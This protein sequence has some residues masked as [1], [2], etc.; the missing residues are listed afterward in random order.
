[1][2][3]F[4]HAA[5]VVVDGESVAVRLGAGVDVAGAFATAVGRVFPNVAAGG[6]RRLS[7][8]SAGATTTVV[9][10]SALTTPVLTSKANG[11]NATA[12]FVAQGANT[13]ALNKLRLSSDF[14]TAFPQANLT[15]YS[16]YSS[17]FRSEV[18]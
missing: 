9:G 11:T 8:T 3:L 4:S 14:G 6:A 10:L 1:V 12:V 17:S 13:G 15:A 7:A 18:S 16:A 5:T 2:T